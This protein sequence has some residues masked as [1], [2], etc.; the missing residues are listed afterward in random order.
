M[1]ARR[2]QAKSL[3]LQGQ[4]Q[5]RSESVEQVAQGNE[6]DFITFYE[7]TTLQHFYQPIRPGS[8]AQHTRA[9]VTI[10]NGPSL[11]ESTTQVFTPMAGHRPDE[12]GWHL[13]LQRHN[14]SYTLT[15][16]QVR[17]RQQG[18]RHQRRSGVTGQ[19]NHWHVAKM[20]ERQRLSWLDCQFPQCQLALFPQCN[21]QKICFPDRN[22]AG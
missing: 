21:T 3:Q 13:E 22:P 1:Q 5:R 4:A 18:K 19:A 11:L 8:T 16:Q 17:S 7:R 15:P 9:L 2:F 6:P 10:N 14:V 20:A 12:T